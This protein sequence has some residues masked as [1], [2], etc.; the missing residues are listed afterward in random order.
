[1]READLSRIRRIRAWFRNLVRR[2]RALVFAIAFFWIVSQGLS[3]PFEYLFRLDREIWIIQVGT[4]VAMTIEGLVFGVLGCLI[5]EGIRKA[6]ISV[7]GA[8]VPFP[9]QSRRVLHALRSRRAPVLAGVLSAAAAAYVWGLHP[10]PFVHDEAAYLL[11]AKLYSTGRWIGPAAPIPEF[12]EQMYTFVWPYTAAKY[13]PG[14]PL[15][16]VPGVWLG[17]PVLVPI[18]LVGIAGAL[19]FSLA[20]E[21][22]NEIVA[23]MTWLLWTTIP[24]ETWPMPPF[25]SQ[26]LSTALLLATWYAL[27]R[28]RKVGRSQS[29][30]CVAFFMGCEGITRPFTFAVAAIPVVLVV[31]VI[32]VKRRCWLQLGGALAIDIAILSVIP[33]WSFKT[34]GDPKVT[35]LALHLRWYTPYDNIGFGWDAPPPVRALPPDLRNVTRLLS[36][37]RRHHT[38]SRVPQLAVGRALQ[39]RLNAFPRWRALLL[40]PIAYGIF[41]VPAEG[42]FAGATALLIFLAH[43]VLAHPVKLSM[44]YMET[45]PVLTF[46]AAIGTWRLVVGERP[47]ASEETADPETVRAGLQIGVLLFAMMIPLALDDLGRYR[48]WERFI[49]ARKARFRSVVAKLPGKSMIFVRY[50]PGFAAFIT[51]IENGPDLSRQKAWIVHDLGPEN[52]RLRAIAPDR[53][54]YLYV[55]SVDV[56]VRLDQPISPQA[57]KRL[58]LVETQPTVNFVGVPLDDR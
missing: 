46:L 17:L 47:A 56:L 10:A 20:R 14:F 4:W 2:N 29:L 6:I 53:T 21:I 40:L 3:Y 58:E 9:R 33:L 43:L 39:I 54:P 16:L 15:A 8:G 37:D 7:A 44:Y 32:V 24:H 28:W 31:L 13:P 38:L 19:V 11:Q 51:L 30:F 55:P 26:H 18:A 57:R 5:V 23:A 49:P 42:L 36:R 48:E 27:E 22:S 52:E 1:M 50:P 41:L 45:Y 12:F 35:P 25:M 34:T